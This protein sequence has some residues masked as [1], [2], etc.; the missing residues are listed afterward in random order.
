MITQSSSELAV[1]QGR[2]I[3]TFPR[4]LWIIWFLSIPG[5]LYLISRLI[6]EQTFLTWNDGPQNI[7]FTLAHTGPILPLYGSL[8]TLIIWFL[9]SIVWLI[10]RVVKRE[11]IRRVVLTIIISTLALL[12]LFPVSYGRWQSLMISI[13]GPGNHGTELLIF[14]ASMGS[15]VAVQTLL[16]EGV[17]VNSTDKEGSTAI[18]AASAQGQNAMIELLL[19]EGADL[20]LKDQNRKTAVDRAVEMNHPITEALLRRHGGHPGSD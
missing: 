6:F 15:V 5:T 20:S 4:S 14:F 18:M 7:G 9:V 1:P 19:Q 3:A 13:R 8:L 17:D 16:D 2:R 11:G 12:S 10:A